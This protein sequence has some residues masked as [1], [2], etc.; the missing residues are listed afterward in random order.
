MKIA[1]KTVFLQDIRVDRESVCMGDDCTAPNEKRFPIRE[2]DMLS[3]IFQMIAGYL[4][5]MRDVVWAVDSGKKIVGYI[6]MDMNG[7]VRYEFCLEDQVFYKL[8]MKALHC[9][10]FYQGKFVYT[11]GEDGAVVE[12]YPEC[13]TLLD[14]AKR[15]MKERFLDE[16]RVKGGSLCIWGEWFGR[17]HDN[18]HIVD[19]VQWTKNEIV[20]TFNE[21]E[22]LYISNPVGIINENERLVIKDATRVLWV[23]YDYGR[24]HTYENLYVRQYTKSADGKIIRAEGKRRDIKKDDGVVFFPVGENAVCLD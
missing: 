19:T 24:E 23:W 2:S 21:E 20:L 16:L 22:S 6:M 8:D 11:N 5:Y 15:C 3:D 10:Y 17:P 7:P 9:S 12:K 1:K 14:K 13:K 18:F 4:P